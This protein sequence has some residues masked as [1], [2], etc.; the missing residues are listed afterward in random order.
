MAAV[1]T[2]TTR[3]ARL[4]A[5]LEEAYGRPRCAREDPL[6]CLVGTILSQ[7]TSDA[8][9]DRQYDA[10]R[11]RFGTWERVARAPVGA[12]ASAIRSGGLARIKAERIAAA[13]RAT[14]KRQVDFRALRRAP[15]PEALSELRRLPGVGPKTAAC[16]LLFSLGRP[17]FPVDTHIHRIARRLGL[18]PQRATAEQT[19]EILQRALDRVRRDPPGRRGAHAAALSLH[20]N[21]IRHGRLVCRPR[22]RCEVCVLRRQCAYYAAVARRS[23]RIRGG[24]IEA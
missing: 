3:L 6:N 24:A 8:N 17:A 5:T 2:L 15:V 9:S 18:V 7:N 13:L 11:R 1:R 23:G 16:V 10:L 20:V 19:Q 22:P 4:D 21:L 14:R 12:I